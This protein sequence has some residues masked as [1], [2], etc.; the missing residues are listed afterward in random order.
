MFADTSIGATIAPPPRA[1]S[2]LK[3]APIQ[4]QHRAGTDRDNAEAGFFLRTRRFSR[5]TILRSKE[6][7]MIE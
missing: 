4:F 7:V 6:P 3:P 2:E 1:Y 5:G